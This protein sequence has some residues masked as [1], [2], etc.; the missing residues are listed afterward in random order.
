MGAV[1]SP[2]RGR[3]YKNS[4]PPLDPVDESTAVYFPAQ[5]RWR[6]VGRR[7][8]VSNLIQVPSSERFGG[9]EST[10]YNFGPGDRVLYLHKYPAV[11][12]F[13]VRC[14]AIILEIVKS[15]RCSVLLAFFP[16]FDASMVPQ[17][18]KSMEPV[19]FAKEFGTAWVEL[20]EPR[21]IGRSR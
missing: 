21:E 6:F 3:K 12:A 17:V 18:V 5:A 11:C 13:V 14:V 16:M 15:S 10:V 7:G 8:T 4:A 2:L 1:I 9:S 19:P 20:D